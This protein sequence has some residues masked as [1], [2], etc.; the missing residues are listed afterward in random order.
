MFSNPARRVLCVPLGCRAKGGNV[1]IF[2]QAGYIAALA[3]FLA[4][5]AWE[6]GTQLFEIFQQ[7][8]K[9]NVM[10]MPEIHKYL[11]VL[12]VLA[13]AVHCLHRKF[14]SPG[15]TNCASHSIPGP[16]GTR[17]ST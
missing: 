1:I 5:V 6:K 10:L 7:Q 4:T 12:H 9:G 17:T 3:S 2:T 11:L 8:I 15:G 14:F 13:T 16:R